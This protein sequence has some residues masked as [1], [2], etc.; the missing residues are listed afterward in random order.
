MNKSP[1][2][3]CEHVNGDKNKCLEHCDKLKEYQEM[4]LKEGIYAKM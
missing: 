4:I 2:I 3:G 1:C